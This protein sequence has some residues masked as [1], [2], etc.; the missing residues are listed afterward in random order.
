M[1]GYL[2]HLQVKHLFNEDHVK[3]S[4]RLYRFPFCHKHAYVYLSFNPY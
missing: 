2:I 4:V 3:F 1:N